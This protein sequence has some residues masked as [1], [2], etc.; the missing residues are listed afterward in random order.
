[1]HFLSVI[2]I[3]PELSSTGIDI[4][5]KADNWRSH[6]VEKR[7][8]SFAACYGFVTHQEVF[9]P[10]EGLSFSADNV[11][12]RLLVLWLLYYTIQISFYL[13]YVL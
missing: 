12:D 2:V 1:M 6:I 11:L 4:W 10:P 9:N 13:C 7:T 3:D 5:Q 8:Q